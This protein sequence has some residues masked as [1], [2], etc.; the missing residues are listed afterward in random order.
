MAAGEF[1]PTRPKKRHRRRANESPVGSLSD[2][3]A[4]AAMCE[5]FIPLA[6]VFVVGLGETLW[7]SRERTANRALVS[8]ELISPGSVVAGTGFEPGYERCEDPCS[9]AENTGSSAIMRM[10]GRLR[11]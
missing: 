7:L 4:V 3:L 6:T 2:N 11:Q 1:V 10:P 5:T 9:S 8:G